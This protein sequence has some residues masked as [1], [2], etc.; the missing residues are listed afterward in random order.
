MDGNGV[1]TATCFIPNSDLLFDVSCHALNNNEKLLAAGTRQGTIILW[2]VNDGDK[3]EACGSKGVM[4][5]LSLEP[6]ILFVP[7]ANTVAFPVIDVAFACSR[8]PIYA[9]KSYEKCSTRRYTGVEIAE[10]VMVSLHKDNTLCVWSLN[11][12][13]C[14]HKVRGPPFAIN[15][16]CPLPDRRFICLVGDYKINV[17]DLWKLKF[18]VTLE[19]YIGSCSDLKSLQDLSVSSFEGEL[20]SE[21]P[22]SHQNSSRVI[23]SRIISANASIPPEANSVAKIPSQLSTPRSDMYGFDSENNHRN[24]GLETRPLLLV[25]LLENN[26][27]LVWDLAQVLFTYKL[28]DEPFDGCTMTVTEWDLAMPPS[29]DYSNSESVMVNYPLRHSSYSVGVSNLSSASGTT[30][31]VAA[32]Q[33]QTIS[34][35]S[36][37]NGVVCILDHIIFLLAD[38]RI[39]V[40][41]YKDESI[42]KLSIMAAVESNSDDSLEYVDIF[43]KR[44]SSDSILLFAWTLDGTMS[45]YSLLLN[46]PV[47]QFVKIGSRKFNSI[48]R[49]CSRV[50]LIVK[51]DKLDCLPTEVDDNIYQITMLG[52]VKGKYMILTEDGADKTINVTNSLL[53]MFHRMNRNVIDTCIY[54]RGNEIYKI[55]L[56]QSGSLLITNL[57]TNACKELCSPSYLNAILDTLVISK[58]QKFVISGAKLLHYVDNMNSDYNGAQR[59]NQAL[60]HALSGEYFLVVIDQRLFVYSYES[61]TLVLVVNSF[62][63][64]TTRGVYSIF[65]MSGNNIANEWNLSELEDHVAISTSGRIILLNIAILLKHAV[66]SQEACTHL[67]ALD[68]PFV[69][70]TKDSALLNS[71]VPCTDTCG[72]MPMGYCHI[73]RKGHV[74]RLVLNTYR[75][76]LY[77]LTSSNVIIYSLSKGCCLYILSQLDVYRRAFA[78]AGNRSTTPYQRSATLVD[79][80]ASY[81]PTDWQKSS[82]S[83]RDDIDTRLKNSIP[84]DLLLLCMFN[85][86]CNRWPVRGPVSQSFVRMECANYSVKIRVLFKETCAISR[87]WV[88]YKFIR[89][90]KQIWTK[91]THVVTKRMPILIYPIS[92]MCCHGNGYVDIVKICDY[93]L[94]CLVG[95]G[96]A[97]SIQLGIDTRFNILDQISNTSRQVSSYLLEHYTKRQNLHRSKSYPCLPQLDNT[98]EREGINSF[99]ATGLLLQDLYL[100]AKFG[101]RNMKAWA[102]DA[103]IW[104][105]GQLLI[106][107]KN[108]IALCNLLNALQL[109][110]DSIC[111]DLLHL[112]VAR[113][114]NIIRCAESV[115]KGM[116]WIFPWV[117]V[118]ECKATIF[119][120]GARCNSCSN[121]KQKL[122]HMDYDRIQPPRDYEED[123]SVILLMLI[124]H[125]FHIFAIGSIVKIGARNYTLA[126][127]VAQ[128]FL[129]I[130][131][132]PKHRLK[133]E[134]F[135]CNT[136]ILDFFAK[137]FG[138]I[139]TLDIFK[140]HSI[141]PDYIKETKLSSVLSPECNKHCMD[142]MRFCLHVF[143]EYHLTSKQSWLCI[144]QSCF[145]SDPKLVLDAFKWIVR[146]R[147]IDKGYIQ[148]AITTLIKLVKRFKSMAIDHLFDIV[149]I[150]I[151][152]LDPNDPSVR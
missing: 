68:E 8:T 3:H 86:Q 133:K 24:K 139:W 97:L 38:S 101:S 124:C 74:E 29:N 4:F 131:F 5:Q 73:L 106:S 152:S 107:S 13:K 60:I 141:L 111:K 140:R 52:I 117:T 123:V 45:I 77:I 37:T 81:L 136:F 151:Q 2:R 120:F 62:D 51:F 80:L 43:A 82:S 30:L 56:L 129:R 128:F 27:M 99:M 147:K 25:A 26:N 92:K 109:A 91:S 104:I 57:K 90:P 84:D 23:E 96:G 36:S 59:I 55:D 93:G 7:C 134:G 87:K 95:S 145:L 44:F 21:Y 122:P 127:Y 119:T 137:S 9:L 114:L 31:R 112:H 71:I 41:I 61:L 103:N 64:N 115:K 150:I 65:K 108:H 143:G 50:Q 113:A 17:I 53:S 94:Y 116:K 1:Y 15:K 70:N 33:C 132:S 58:F 11:D 22:L 125:R 47:P 142:S 126:V 146:E 110:I 148:T 10:E 83:S 48:H 98:T 76:T 42:N 35:L 118:C 135:S 72:I 54:S 12:F 105:L 63:V 14:I 130:I 100:S 39:F 19:P 85:E 149:A 18:I 138:T 79:T 49:R 144:L 102:K 28:Q 6:R 20:M 89:K 40:W 67:R 46:I 75:N 121:P 32:R 66:M 69:L 34:E 16:I 78:F 88:G